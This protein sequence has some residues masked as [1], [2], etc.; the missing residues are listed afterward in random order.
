MLTEIEVE[1]LGVMRHLNDWQQERWFRMPRG[2]NRVIAPAAYGLGMSL[3]QFKRLP[4]DRQKAA[5]QA[6]DRLTAP[7]PM[8]GMERTASRQNRLPQPWERVS[9]ARQI[10]LGNILIAKQAELQRGHF[11]PW[12]EDVGISRGQARRWMQKARARI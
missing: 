11:G 6:Y 9:E 12:L 2:R 7:P 4:I 5:L 3:Q 10:E 8:K 1:G